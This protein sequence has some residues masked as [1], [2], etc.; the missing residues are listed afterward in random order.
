MSSMSRA[1]C[2]IILDEKTRSLDRG[3]TVEVEV[4]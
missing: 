2:V 4:L 1:N 3:A